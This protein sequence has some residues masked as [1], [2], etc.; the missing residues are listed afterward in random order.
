V[1]IAIGRDYLVTGMSIKETSKKHAT[2][3]GNVQR[4]VARISRKSNRR[5]YGL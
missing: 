3:P 5:D 4:I 2:T 1:S